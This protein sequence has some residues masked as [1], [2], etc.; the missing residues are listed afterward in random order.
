VHSVGS[1]SL[2]MFVL[3]INKIKH[4]VMFIYL[5]MEIKTLINGL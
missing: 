2:L 4:C 5:A 3:E 1:L